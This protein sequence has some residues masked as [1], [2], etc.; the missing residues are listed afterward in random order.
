MA[1]Q[2]LIALKRPSGQFY[3]SLTMMK[4]SQSL[5]NMALQNLKTA[6]NSWK[7][8][9]ANLLIFIQMARLLETKYITYAWGAFI[10][11]AWFEVLHWIVAISMH[12]MIVSCV[13]S[14]K[15][16]WKSGCPFW[17]QKRSFFALMIIFYSQN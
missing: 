15:F 5:F 17:I 8:L 2:F 3:A 9:P 7:I 13:K 14:K 16:I 10:L 11:I 6:I 12:T 1:Y 4:H